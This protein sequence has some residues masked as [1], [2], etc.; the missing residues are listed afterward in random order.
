MAPL[1]I[2][3]ETKDRKQ[4]ALSAF[5]YENIILNNKKILRKAK[6]KW[7]L[8]SDKVL[9]GVLNDYYIRRHLYKIKIMRAVLQ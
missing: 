1:K 8:R 7:K 3:G 5:M 2:I 9:V 4:K 6:N